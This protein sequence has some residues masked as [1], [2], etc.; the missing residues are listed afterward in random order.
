MFPR[1]CKDL[2][3]DLDSKPSSTSEAVKALETITS[4]IIGFF[5]L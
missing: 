4:A 5:N 3:P 1:N 2:I